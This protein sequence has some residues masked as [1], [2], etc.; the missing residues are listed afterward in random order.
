MTLRL[1]AKYGDACNLTGGVATFR[2][3]LEVLREHCRAVGRDYDEILKTKLGHVVIA[4]DAQEARSMAE[5]EG[6]TSERLND[7]VIYGTPD[8]V[9]KA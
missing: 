2:H 4:R 6:Y 5:S 1:V 9:R 3:K 7:Y 8:R